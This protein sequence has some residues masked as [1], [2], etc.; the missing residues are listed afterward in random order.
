M[1]DLSGIVKNFQIR[2]IHSDKFDQAYKKSSG[3]RA[4]YSAV[5]IEE[6]FLEVE[7]TIKTSTMVTRDQVAV[8][9]KRVEKFCDIL[10]LDLT[11]FK[12]GQKF[13]FDYRG[14]NFVNLILEILDKYG[15]SPT[16][17]VKVLSDEEVF[18]LEDSYG[19][20]LESVGFS[21]ESRVEIFRKTLAIQRENSSPDFAEIM[22]RTLASVKFFYPEEYEENW[23]EYLLQFNRCIDEELTSILT[24]I[25]CEQLEIF[26]ENKTKSKD[27][28]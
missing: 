15:V 24:K 9:K 17:A 18:Y 11:L 14:Q 3:S 10:D 6:V 5:N 12:E 4:K 26:L 19:K 8:E 21:S 1:M 13:E 27:Q 22:D 2:K 7:E 23:S 28:Q 20:A 16:K 25:G